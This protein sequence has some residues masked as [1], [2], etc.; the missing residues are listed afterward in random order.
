MW[1]AV[2]EFAPGLR[3]RCLL[4]LLEAVSSEEINNDGSK[5]EVC[6][7]QLISFRETLSFSIAKIAEPAQG[8][9]GNNQD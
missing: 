2:K 4:R 7:D 8:T 1:S 3:S 9:S 5:N 6:Y